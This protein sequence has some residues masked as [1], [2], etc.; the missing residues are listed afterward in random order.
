MFS[1]NNQIYLMFF[2]QVPPIPMSFSWEMM[3]Y[4]EI[5]DGD[6]D[7]TDTYIHSMVHRM[8]GKDS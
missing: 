5:N 4:L 6:E 2:F 7:D 1:I 3:M 8:E